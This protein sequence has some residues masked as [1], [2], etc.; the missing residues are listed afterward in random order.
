MTTHALSFAGRPW[1]Q[2]RGAR[3]TAR[4]DGSRPPAKGEH[5][6]PCQRIACRNGTAYWFNEASLRYYCVACA[7]TFNE[8]ARRHGQPPLCALHL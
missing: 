6:G 3:P 4:I 7:R 1:W 2:I 8:V 5:G